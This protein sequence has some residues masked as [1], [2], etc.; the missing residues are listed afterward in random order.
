MTTVV[1]SYDFPAWMREHFA[2][3]ELWDWARQ[4]AQQP[5]LAL[6]LRGAPGTSARFVRTHERAPDPSIW[7]QVLRFA[8]AVFTP[9]DDASGRGPVTA[10]APMSF[11]RRDGALRRWSTHRCRRCR[12]V[13]VPQQAI[14]KSRICSRRRHLR[15][16]SRCGATTRRARRSPGGVGRSLS[17]QGLR[18]RS[19]CGT[20]GASVTAVSP[21]PQLR[22]RAGPLGRLLRSWTSQR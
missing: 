16:R 9:L 22:R 1:A 3:S 14:E 7:R 21:S 4:R 17:R 11:C 6:S 13:P 18:R 20:S 8:E 10:C 2:V 12:P 15:H 5:E 19:R